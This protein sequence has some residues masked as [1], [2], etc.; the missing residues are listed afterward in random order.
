MLKRS[1]L[2]SQFSVCLPFCSASVQFSGSLFF[3]S[4]CFS[5]FSFLLLLF[6]VHLFVSVQCPLLFLFSASFFFFSFCFIDFSFFLL[7]FSAHLFVSRVA[8]FFS[9]KTFF[10]AQNNS[11]FS[12]KPFS[13]QPTPLFQP[14]FVLFHPLFFLFHVLPSKSPQTCSALFV[15]ASF[16]VS[17]QLLRP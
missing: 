13:I 16:L 1:R 11:L 3:F 10:S 8:L 2:A 17:C 12:P 9:P 14:L 4:F 5:I 15:R 6:S 7:L